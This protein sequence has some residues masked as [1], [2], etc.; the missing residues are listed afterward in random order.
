LDQILF[1]LLTLGRTLLNQKSFVKLLWSGEH[2]FNGNKTNKIPNLNLS[3]T[4]RILQNHMYAPYPVCQT[5]NKAL[6]RGR[7]T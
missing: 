3:H 5:Q 7:F 6:P 2:V 1:S 4:L